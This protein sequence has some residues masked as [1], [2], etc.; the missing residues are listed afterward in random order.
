MSRPHTPVTPHATS[1]K[2]PTAPSRERQG[3]DLGIFVALYV[4][5]CTALRDFM[6]PLGWTAYKV[7]L[8]SRRYVMERM[9]DLRGRSYAGIVASLAD[10]TTT[11]K[12]LDNANEWFKTP[13]PDVSADPVTAALLSQLPNGRFDDGVVTFRLPHGLT[14]TD[15]E[16][17]FKSALDPRNLNTVLAT[18]DGRKR[19]KQVGLPADARLFT[20]YDLI[21]GR[22]SL[23]SEIF[24]VRPEREA[25]VLLQALLLSIEQER[26]RKA[27]C[28]FGLPD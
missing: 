8:T 19:L 7:G 2:F 25:A 1:F 10:R 12:R 15:L 3:L 4:F 6:Q 21:G 18:A 28:V 14:L 24:C 23:T 5:G 26:E 27:G 17:R 13:L 16:R 11:L 22:R 9:H 20:D